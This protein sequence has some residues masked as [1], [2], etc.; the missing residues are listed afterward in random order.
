ML[1]AAAA[2]WFSRAIG[3]PLVVNGAARRA[4]DRRGFQRLVNEKLAAQFWPA[5]KLAAMH[6][7]KLRPLLAHAGGQVPY[8][9]DLF[10]QTGFDPARINSVDDLKALPSLSRRTVQ[11]Q[12]DRLLAD[13]MRRPGLARTYT[14]GSTGAP[15][16]LWYD[17]AFNR[18][19]EA[20]AW[21]SDFVAG[22]RIGSRTAYLWSAP[23]DVVADRGW[24]GQ[25][26]RWLRNE[27]I[28]DASA[29]TEADLLG[30][31]RAMQAWPPEVLVGYAHTL[32]AFARLLEKRGLKPHYPRKS[33]I[34]SGEVLHPGMRADL[35]RVFPA[36]VFNRYGSREAG[37]LA[38][39]CERHTGLHLNLPNILVE[40]V[41]PD[42]Y[43]LPADV[44]VT[45]LHNYAMPLIRYEM[46]DRALLAEGDCACGRS[47]P[48]L[49]QI[50]GRTGAT[51]VSRTG[52]MV[53]ANYLFPA[54]RRVPGVVEFQLRQDAIGQVR[55][56]AVP[57]PGCTPEGFEPLRAEVAKTFGPDT[58]L[59][60]EFVEHI[61]RS[62][63][64][65]VQMTVSHVP[66][67]MDTD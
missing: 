2:E 32:A 62:P 58:E 33:L 38:Y 13:N 30:Y 4:K 67:P 21:V 27:A 36:A 1:R 59:L 41:G 17:R 57:G 65:K 15:M 34:T 14:G 29:A 22:R 50:V 25:A 51:F 42:P 10:R 66:L 5:E 53:E 16:A 7:A 11:A 19:F 26:R 63:S 18:H 54:A 31:H 49:S 60:V 44:L 45:E 48:R 28:F 8:Y 9:R 47:A 40:C 64:G 43:H 3:Y 39:E 52:R 55:V 23:R 24:R 35:E 37:L 20:S 6:L 61:P 46:N 12:G 56:L